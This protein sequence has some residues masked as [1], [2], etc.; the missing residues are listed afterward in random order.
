MRDEHE[1]VR[2]AALLKI[3]LA[4]RA[5]T[6]EQLHT[7]LGKYHAGT[8]PTLGPDRVETMEHSLQRAQDKQ[9]RE[10]LIYATLRWALAG[11]ETIDETD[12]DL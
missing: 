6:I 9:A 3:A 12:L 2:R 11:S 5:V 1:V 10:G 4:K 7:N 8:A